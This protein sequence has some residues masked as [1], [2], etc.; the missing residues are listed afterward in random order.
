MVSG[1]LI[2]RWNVLQT[3]VVGVAEVIGLVEIPVRIKEGKGAMAQ[4]IAVDVSSLLWTLPL[5]EQRSA[6][7]NRLPALYPSSRFPGIK[8]PDC[9]P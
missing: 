5:F 8:R 9:L 1:F 2:V 4:Y 6:P 3:L 7:S